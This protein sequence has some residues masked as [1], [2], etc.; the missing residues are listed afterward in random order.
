MPNKKISTEK[1]LVEEPKNEKIELL[2]TE[3]SNSVFP[4]D[5]TPLI[6]KLLKMGLEH[7][8]AGFMPEDGEPY[9]I[10]CEI[11]NIH[12]LEN[13][14]WLSKVS[15]KQDGRLG[16]TKLRQNFIREHDCKKPTELMLADQVVRSYWRIMD[17][18]S[19]IQIFLTRERG[20]SQLDLNYL[21]ELHKGIELAH[22]ELSVSLTL[23]I[24]LKQPQVNIK[25][26]T[27][28][29]FFAQNQQVN[30]EQMENSKSDIESGEIINTK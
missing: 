12:G 23:L 21:R 17:Y 15:N 7:K 30:Q 8:E 29:A 14:L 5:D 28:N 16:I 1:K 4:T 13:G 11:A 19:R 2:R 25:V 6:K 24:Q 22:R 27:E 26:S 18:E 20:L 9:E 10:L 3:L